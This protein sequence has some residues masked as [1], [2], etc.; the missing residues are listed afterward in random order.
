MIVSKNVFRSLI[1]SGI[2]LKI[3][4]NDADF[5]LSSWNA[6]SVRFKRYSITILQCGATHRIKQNRNYLF[7]CQHIQHALHFMW[8]TMLMQCKTNLQSVSE[9]PPC[10]LNILSFKLTF[11][12]PFFKM[13]ITISYDSPGCDCSA[14]VNAARSVCDATKSRRSSCKSIKSR[15][16]STNRS[17]IDWMD[18]FADDRHLPA[19]KLDAIKLVRLAL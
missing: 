3:R 2:R 6:S 18:V 12:S 11:K 7:R 19:T 13:P 5:L 16:H 17:K 9:A 1:S 4:F 8:M 10:S 14:L 15:I